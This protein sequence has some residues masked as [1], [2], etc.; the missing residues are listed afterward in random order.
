M[1]V[2]GDTVWSETP[3]QRRV[4]QTVE[5]E[6][7]VAQRLEARKFWSR[8]PLTFRDM[9]LIFPNFVSPLVSGTF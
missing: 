7:G 2:D 9:R 6:Q 5:M 3:L 8:Q 4:L 1:G